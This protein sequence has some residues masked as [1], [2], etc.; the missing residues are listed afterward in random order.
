MHSRNHGIPFRHT[1]VATIPAMVS[2]RLSND[3]MKMGEKQPLKEQSRGLR[4]PWR[5]DH[6]LWTLVQPFQT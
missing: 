2:M 4:K 5:L 1:R 3:E 6:G